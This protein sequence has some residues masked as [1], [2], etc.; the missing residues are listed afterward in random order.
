MFEQLGN[1]SERRVSRADN[2][3]LKLVTIGCKHVLDSGVTEL[4]KLDGEPGLDLWHQHS[5]Q[6]TPQLFDES[7]WR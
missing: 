7:Y 6:V 3:N 1:A 2:H 5:L 4:V